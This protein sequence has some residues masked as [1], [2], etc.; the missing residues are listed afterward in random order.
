MAS[1]DNLD[2]KFMA[3]ISLSAI[4]HGDAMLARIRKLR[5]RAIN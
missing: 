4:P 5:N 1:D 3:A 2:F